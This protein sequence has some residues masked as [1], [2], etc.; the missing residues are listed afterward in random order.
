MLPT[1]IAL[2]GLCRGMVRILVPSVITICL[3]WRLTQN[4]TFCNA[5]TA[6]RWFTPG[7]LGILDLDFNLAYFGVLNELVERCQVFVDGLRY[8]LESFVLRGALG[9]AAGKSGNGNSV[10]LI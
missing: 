3:P 6:S 5:R 2:T 4:P 7:S 10:A 9:M 1:V 8:A